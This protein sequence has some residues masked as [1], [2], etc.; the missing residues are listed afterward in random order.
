MKW[1]IKRTGGKPENTAPSFANPESNW[2]QEE[3]RSEAGRNRSRNKPKRTV[4]GSIPISSA[5]SN[6]APADRPAVGTHVAFYER[7][8]DM[9]KQRKRLPKTV[10]SLTLTMVPRTDANPAQEIL[11]QVNLLGFDIQEFS[12]NTFVINGLPSEMA[13]K[14]TRSRSSN[15]L[16]NST[17]DLDMK[18]DAGK[19]CPRHGALVQPSSGENAQRRRDAGADRPVVCLPGAL[20]ALPGRIVS[21]PLSWT[22]WPNDLKAEVFLYKNIFTAARL[23]LGLPTL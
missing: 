18:L 21:S 1:R 8:L 3:R 23:C 7:F 6:R 10:V 2:H 16:L 12:V 22:N 14:R 5:R 4:S 20:K 17:K 19:H 13:G 15:R 9:L 11:G